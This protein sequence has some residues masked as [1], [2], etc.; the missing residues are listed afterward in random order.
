MEDT[1]SGSRSLDS[2]NVGSKR[3]ESQKAA[4]KDISTLD[5][6]LVLVIFAILTICFLIGRSMAL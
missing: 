4:W 5:A 3:A 6:P 1:N 2:R